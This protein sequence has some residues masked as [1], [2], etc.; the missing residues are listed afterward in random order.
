M[1]LIGQLLPLEQGE[2]AFVF[3][4]PTNWNSLQRIAKL[5]NLAEQAEFTTTVNTTLI[6]FP[7]DFVFWFGF[8]I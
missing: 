4:A 5:T 6:D 7:L 3:S 2:I 8:A 1:E